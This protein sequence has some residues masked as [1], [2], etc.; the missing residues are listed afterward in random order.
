ML[1]TPQRPGSSPWR[2]KVTVEAEPQTDS[3]Q[4]SASMDTPSRAP[5]ARVT[6]TTVPLKAPDESSPVKRGRGRPRKSSTTV[7]LRDPGDRSPVKRGRGRPRKSSVASP[8]PKKRNGTPM[9]RPR[10]SITRSPDEDD[11]ESSVSDF[12][13]TRKKTGTP[14]RR[15]KRSITKVPDGN[16]EASS[17][18]DLPQPKILG[19]SRKSKPDGIAK[20][21]SAEEI[22]EMS[23]SENQ[24]DTPE[25][26]R[27]SQQDE[28]ENLLNTTQHLPASRPSSS[29]PYSQTL[30]ES[31]N[32]GNSHLETSAS[33]DDVVPNAAVHDEL[34]HDANMWRSMIRNQSHGV[35]HESSDEVETSDDEACDVTV[36]DVIGEATMLS[37]EGFSMVSIDSLPSRQAKTISPKAKRLPTKDAENDAETTNQTLAHQES[38]NEEA[39]HLPRNR[40]IGDVSLTDLSLSYMPSSPPVRFSDRTPSATFLK[41]PSAPPRIEQTQYNPTEQ[42]TPKLGNVVRAGIAL[43]G[44]VDGNKR[45]TLDRRPSDDVREEEQRKRLDDLF[46]KFASGT[47]RELRA[48]LRLGEQLKQRAQSRAA[49]RESTFEPEHPQSAPAGT[50]LGLDDNIF[51]NVR[52]NASFAS[53][54]GRLPTPEETGDYALHG[55]PE[56]APSSTKTASLN[57]L[58]VDHP[59]LQLIS[60]AKSQEEEDSDADA[61]EYADATPSPKDTTSERS[62]NTSVAK[63]DWEDPRNPGEDWSHFWERRR[64]A[65][66][67]QVDEANASQAIVVNSDDDKAEQ[68]L[69][70]ET[71]GDIWEEAASSSPSADSTKQTNVNRSKERAD[72]L[73]VNERIV[74]Y[75][76]RP[77]PSVTIISRAE[78][79]RRSEQLHPNKSPE[80][81]SPQSLT[82]TQLRQRQTSFESRNEIKERRAA[83]MAERRAKKDSGEVSASLGAFSSSG[84][85]DDSGSFFQHNL[86]AV[87]KKTKDGKVV[88]KIEIS[89][90]ENQDESSPERKPIETTQDSSHVKLQQVQ[91]IFA[92]NVPPRSSPLKRQVFFSSPATTERSYIG[93]KSAIR[94]EESAYQDV[95]AESMTSDIRQLR[96]EIRTRSSDTGNFEGVDEAAEYDDEEDAGDDVS[97]GTEPHEIECPTCQHRSHYAP[98][99][100]P[101]KPLGPLFPKPLSHEAKSSSAAPIAAAEPE[102]VNQ[103]SGLL[104][105]LWSMSPFG[106]GSPSSEAPLH[107]LAAPLDPLPK[108]FP[109]TLTHY[110]G[111]D[112]LYS[113]YKKQQVLFSPNN[114]ENEGLLSQVHPHPQELREVNPRHKVTLS[115]YIGMEITKWGYTVRIT[116]RQLVLCAIFMQ[117]LTLEDEAEYE[118]V[119]GHEMERYPPNDEPHSPIWALDVILMFFTLFASDLVRRDERKGLAIDRTGEMTITWPEGFESMLM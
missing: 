83:R 11:G 14:R 76:K 79:R 15:A 106:S 73:P 104:S 69:A 10:K 63:P 113:R 68:Q 44:V 98:K 59:N 22:P 53:F 118:R 56:T 43:Q 27:S 92:A 4:V 99:L 30:A 81:S 54:S 87:F 49:T 2:I 114:P 71:F 12:S 117:R 1:S 3:S 45:G 5:I 25:S 82:R 6:T 72:S 61:G 34:S 39:L 52:E 100:S 18:S 116:Q 46:S 91:R 94:P 75:S 74:D 24:E 90:V 95:T 50:G 85:S 29:I 86:P 7:P 84:E 20:S 62:H 89:R 40:R 77:K 96:N 38:T 102:A 33:T 93:N 88:E 9:R 60:P 55:P 70:N 17:A 58:T 51:E 19:R 42:S 107:E 110:K 78:L 31:F 119:V 28:D 108:H 109:W 64:G 101:R 8:A 35:H 112:S 21:L 97:P 67:K 13:Q 48:G 103:Q 32:I 115:S 16:V 111:F 80:R 105:K 37:S 23:A 66:S 26:S 57:T 65:A 47:S 41:S 36:P